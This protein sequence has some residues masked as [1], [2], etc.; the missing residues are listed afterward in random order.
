MYIGTSTNVNAT[1]EGDI[2]EDGT[3]HDHIR[4]VTPDG[5]TIVVDLLETYALGVFGNV[6]IH[7]ADGSIIE[8]V[9]F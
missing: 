9:T 1:I 5:R 3:A 6:W 8:F 7:G 4:I 2:T